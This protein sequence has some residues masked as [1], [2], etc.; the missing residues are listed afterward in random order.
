MAFILY[1]PGGMAQ[2]MHQLGDVTTAGVKRLRAR[3]GGETPDPA[4]P[5]SPD[6][7]PTTGTGT[8]PSTQAGAVAE[9]IS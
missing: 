4:G 6:S 3:W 7:A 5:G 1:L 8:G 9:V 2:V